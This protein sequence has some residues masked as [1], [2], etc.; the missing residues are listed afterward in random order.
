MIKNKCLERVTYH[1]KQTVVNY[2]NNS[3]QR[4]IHITQ[5]LT[6]LIMVIWFYHIPLEGAQILI[7]VQFEYHLQPQLIHVLYI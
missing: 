5:P 3:E 6:N 1:I 2:I 4:F 7:L